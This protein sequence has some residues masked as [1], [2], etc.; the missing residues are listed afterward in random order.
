MA[1]RS[2]QPAVTGLLMFKQCDRRQVK[3]DE[4]KCR[5]QR[6]AQIQWK[7][8]EFFFFLKMNIL[9]YD[10]VHL[11]NHITAPNGFNSLTVNRIS[12]S[13]LN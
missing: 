5:A 2:F 6:F 10:Y 9:I 11:P 8:K 12:P 3:T 7:V 13:L 4:F 1:I